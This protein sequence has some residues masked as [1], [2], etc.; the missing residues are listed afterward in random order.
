MFSLYTVENGHVTVKTMFVHNTCTMML[1]APS[2][3]FK[4][5]KIKD[6]GT[7]S[8]LDNKC[9]RWNCHEK[10]RCQNFQQVLPPE[11]LLAVQPTMSMAKQHMTIGWKLMCCNVMLEANLRMNECFSVEDPF[12]WYHVFLKFDHL[13]EQ[14]TC[15][16]RWIKG[17]MGPGSFLTMGPLARGPG[18]SVPP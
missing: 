5:N 8:Y 14:Y 18:L 13:L 4:K 12:C 7:L 9:E 3:F 16:Q 17:F 11:A 6:V 15:N 10:K 2:A 1:P